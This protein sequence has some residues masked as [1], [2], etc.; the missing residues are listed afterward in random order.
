M[1]ASGDRV[2]TARVELGALSLFGEFQGHRKKKDLLTL[3]ETDL[4]ECV[5]YVTQNGVENL[6]C[7]RCRSVSK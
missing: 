3:N 1:C 7:S 5:Y 6:V 4:E 2:Q